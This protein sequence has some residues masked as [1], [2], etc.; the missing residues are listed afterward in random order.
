[1]EK[2]NKNKKYCGSC[3]DFRYEDVEGNGY[4]E[5][6]NLT[7]SCSN[8][9]LFYEQHNVLRLNLKAKWYEMIESGEKKEEYREIKEY[10][11]K[12]LSNKKYDIVKFVY[13]YTR[14]T[15]MFHIKSIEE[16]TGKEEWGAEKGEIYYVIKLGNMI[17]RVKEE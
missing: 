12:R 6:F 2:E 5:P 1:M 16:S 3:P 17:K 13:G 9:C 7:T 11:T 15:M 4:C 8:T 14:R 10:W